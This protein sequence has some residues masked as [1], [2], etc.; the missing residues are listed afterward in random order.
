MRSLYPSTVSEDLTRLLPTDSPLVPSSFTIKHC[1]CATIEVKEGVE[2]AGHRDSRPES[3]YG[4]DMLEGVPH[5]EYLEENVRG[6][7][8]LDQ[9]GVNIKND[10]KIEIRENFHMDPEPQAI[11]ALIDRKIS[12]INEDI[13]GIVTGDPDISVRKPEHSHLGKIVVDKNILEDAKSEIRSMGETESSVY[14]EKS[15]EFTPES[16]SEQLREKIDGASQEDVNN[17][18]K[19]QADDIIREQVD[20]VKEEA[21]DMIKSEAIRRENELD[22]FK[23]QLSDNIK[24]TIVENVNKIVQSQVDEKITKA[25]S[26]ALKGSDLANTIADNITSKMKGEKEDTDEE[27]SEESEEPPAKERIRLRNK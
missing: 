13:C 17:L 25:V 12:S 6:A 10:I 22:N 14:N 19:E 24:E 7:S 16:A 20:A 27:K 23:A 11:E 18:I 21:D 26:D 5:S 4:L 9:I 1:N 8:F 2:D 3:P 15:G